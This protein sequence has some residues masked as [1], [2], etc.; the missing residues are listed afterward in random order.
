VGVGAAA[1]GGIEWA[2]KTA[3]QPTALPVRQDVTEFAKNAS[4]LAKFEG[5]IKEMQDRS[6]TDPNDPKGWLVNARAHA[7]NCAIAD[8]DPRQI[9]F[10]WWFLSWHRAYITVTERKIREIAGDNTL[11]YPYWNWS[12]DRHIPQAF[13]RSGSPLAKAVRYTPP[14]AVQ[15]G[16]V[17]YVPSDPVLKKLGVAALAA[18]IFEAKQ[19][20][21]ISR[22]LG[23]IARPNPSG[24]YGNSGLEAT[25]HGPIHVYVGGTKSDT[26]VGDMTDFETAARDPIFF[27]HHGNLDRLWEIW[28]RD[29]ARKGTEPT[30][31]SFLSHSF[32]FTWLDG[33]PISISVADTLD[34]STLGYTYDVFD[35]LRPQA[36]LAAA[37]PQGAENRLPPVAREN[38]RVPLSPQAVGDERKILEITNVEK[39][40]QPMTVGVFLK[41][42]NASADEPGI[43][44]GSFAAV[45]SG[46]EISWPSQTLLFDITNAAERFAGQAMS[47]ELVPYRIR[48]QGVE[49][50]AP[51]KYGGMR[52]V[53]EK[54]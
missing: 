19:P 29:P 36:V 53:T 48:A 20:S 52:I 12:S 49:S 8:A 35:V 44:V 42:A 50:Y 10:C 4:Q 15:D 18:T 37:S 24:A 54:P 46:G 33:S 6:A 27:A 1:I 2:T 40:T 9:H 31:S 43:N 11:A 26:E 47:V 34:T 45:K 32:V 23:G 38:L 3:A 28:R 30:S 16:E 5:A 51:L 39:P 7:T 17:G 41:P 25:P 22:T 14:R 21:Q 13:A